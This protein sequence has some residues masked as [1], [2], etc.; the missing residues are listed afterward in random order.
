MV[1]D[2]RAVVSSYKVEIMSNFHPKLLQM[3]IAHH[4]LVCAPANRSVFVDE[5]W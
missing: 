1:P 2:S 3:T 4:F 5:M